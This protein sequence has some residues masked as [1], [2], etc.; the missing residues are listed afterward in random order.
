MPV[1]FNKLFKR[2]FQ[3]RGYVALG[4]RMTDEFERILIEAVVA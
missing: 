1:V 2:R 4:D 3:Y